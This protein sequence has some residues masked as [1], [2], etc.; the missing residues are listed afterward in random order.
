MQ[1]ITLENKIRRRGFTRRE[2]AERVPSSVSR[3][4]QRPPE[5]FQTEVEDTPGL[6]CF[7]PALG[8]FLL[9]LSSR[10]MLGTLQ[11]RGFWLLSCSILSKLT[12]EEGV[13]H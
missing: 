5:G 12:L 3:L 1:T 2:R 13:F 11:H 4:W 10:A 7:S 6:V 9:P 8:G